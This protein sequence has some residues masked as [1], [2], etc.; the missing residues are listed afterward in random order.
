MMALS[1]AFVADTVPK[2]KTGRAMGLLGTMSAIGT[3]L[4]PSLGGLLIAAFGWRAIFLVNVPL[5]LLAFLLTLRHL[6]GAGGM[7]KTQRAGFDYPG[8][9]LLALT[10]AAYALAM[11]LGRGHFGPLNTALLLVALIGLGVF[12]LV[13]TK[14]ASPLVRLTMLRDPALS[15]GLTMSG[16]VATVMMATLVIGP[17]Y[18]ARGL[19]LDTAYVGLAMSVGPVLSALSGV[20]AGHVVDRFG[21]QNMTLAGLCA[22]VAGTSLLCLLPASLGVAGY[23]GAIIVLTPGYALFQAA[24]NTAV[25][26]GIGPEQRGVMSGLVNLARNLGLVTGASVLGAIFAYAAGVVNLASASPAAVAAGMHFTFGVATLL[27]AGA[28]AIG[29]ASRVLAARPA[30]SRDAP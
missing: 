6:P 13:E 5:G 3:A 4:G 27:V 22:M 16:L 12:V 28:I 17:F 30:L 18:L 25:M 8:T 23:V 29:V 7:A 21:A 2:D 24:N 20:P 26:S 9:L 15:A 1:M 10:L 11:T 19:A 14:V